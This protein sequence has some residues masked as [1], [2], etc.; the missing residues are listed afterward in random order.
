[1]QRR[2]RSER[3]D[4]EDAAINVYEDNER[5]RLGQTRKQRF[6][7]CFAPRHP[8]ALLDEELSPVL[9]RRQHM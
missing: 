2:P 4:A 8:F 1:V 6:S 7:R 3:E 9:R 5:G